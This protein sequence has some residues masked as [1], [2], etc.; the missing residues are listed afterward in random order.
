MPNLHLQDISWEIKYTSQLSLACTIIMI[1]ISVYHNDDSDNDGHCFPP[2]CCRKRADCNRMFCEL[3]LFLDL[4]LPSLRGKIG[5][6]SIIVQT[7]LTYCPHIFW[8]SSEKALQKSKLNFTNVTHFKCN[9]YSFLNPYF[10][11]LSPGFLSTCALFSQ[12]KKKGKQQLRTE[13]GRKR[14]RSWCLWFFTLGEKKSTCFLKQ[15]KDWY[16]LQYEPLFDRCVF[17]GFVG[18]HVIQHLGL[19]FGRRKENASVRVFL[20]RAN[21]LGSHIY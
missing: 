17:P 3:D 11:F 14:N 12:Q 19:S 2:L 6:Y 10:P 1:N 5:Q 16:L 21:L 20:G 4:F 7:L 13:N 15:N 8:Y 9:F 18:S